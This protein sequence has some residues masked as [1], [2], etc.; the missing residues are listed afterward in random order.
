MSNNWIPLD[1]VLAVLND[2]E[3]SWVRNMDCKYVE[4]R[5]DTRDNHCVIRARDG[6]AITLE[7]LQYQYSEDTPGAPLRYSV[8]TE[9]V[10]IFDQV[11][12][13][14]SHESTIILQNKHD[15]WC[16]VVANDLSSDLRNRLQKLG[17]DVSI[18]EQADI[19][20][21]VS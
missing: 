2:P 7:D 15:K 16:Q 18:D 11:V 17:A 21:N 14:V 19:D 3:W 13:M 9:Q 1:D 4:I 8:Y 20:A 10:E 5:V 12:E 6:S